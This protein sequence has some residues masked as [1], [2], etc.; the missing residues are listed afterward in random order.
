MSKSNSSLMGLPN[1]LS[2]T[3]SFAYNLKE[4]MIGII[5]NPLIKLSTGIFDLI[6]F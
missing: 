6:G 2:L 4:L 3:F 1:F 5:A